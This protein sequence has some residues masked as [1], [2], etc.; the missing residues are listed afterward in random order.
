MNQFFGAIV[1]DVDPE[2]INLFGKLS[3]RW[4]GLLFA[5]GLIL[6]FQIAKRLFIADGYTLKEIDKLAMYV[7]IAT[8]VGAR[9]GHCLFYEP[10]YYLSHPIEML[11]PVGFDN[12]KMVFQGYQGLAS[13]G[14]ILG[15]FLSIA[16]FCWKSKKS[17]FGVLDKVAVGGSLTGVFIRLGNLMNSEIIGKATGSDAGVI[18]QR[19]D[20]IPRHPGQFYESMAYLLIFFI[21][22][23]LYK[24]QR[25]KFNKGFIFGLFFA[26]LF[27]ARFFIEFF[28]INQVGFED[29]MSLNMGQLLSIPFIIGGISVMV[30]KWKKN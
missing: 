26:L 28:K 29:G 1:W 6:G 18:F 22:F 17:F 10:G 15:V 24:K 20:N 16:L 4:Y 19:V 21:L 12:G 8:I 23:Y 11:L 25:E 3:I 5:G 7:F 13:H 27:I 30:W 14:G 9:L 2:I